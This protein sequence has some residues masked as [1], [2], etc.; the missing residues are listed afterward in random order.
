[1]PWQAHWHWCSLWQHPPRRLVQE[2]KNGSEEASYMVGISGF[3]FGP[4]E[5]L[6]VV[7]GSVVHSALLPKLPEPGD[8]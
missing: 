2:M 3:S 5:H 6:G 8:L 4:A 1:M 7:L